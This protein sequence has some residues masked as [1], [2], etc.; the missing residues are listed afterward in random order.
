MNTAFSDLPVELNCKSQVPGRTGSVQG[1]S[2]LSQ[3]EVTAIRPHCNYMWWEGK[4]TAH[5]DLWLEPGWMDGGWTNEI[6]DGLK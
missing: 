2:S 6:V 3:A 1:H 5:S 4:S